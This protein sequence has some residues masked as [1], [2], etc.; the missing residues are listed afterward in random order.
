LIPAVLCVA[1]LVAVQ[2]SAFNLVAVVLCVTAPDAVSI[3]AVTVSVDAA[4]QTQL[5]DVVLS[6]PVDADVVKENDLDEVVVLE[7]P[8]LLEVVVA[9][10]AL[11]FLEVDVIKVVEDLTGLLVDAV[12]NLVESPDGVEIAAAVTAA[13]TASRNPVFATIW[14]ISHIIMPPKLVKL[15]Q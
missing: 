12:N 4:G 7:V 15:L 9:D 10:V 2:V 11:V 8:V 3:V 5:T 14:L 1:G 6:R 13:N